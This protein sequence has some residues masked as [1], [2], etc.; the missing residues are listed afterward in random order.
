MGPQEQLSCILYEGLVCS[1]EEKCVIKN[2]TATLHKHLK[3][4]VLK[5]KGYR[6]VR[7]LHLVGMELIFT[8]DNVFLQCLGCLIN[9]NNNNKKDIDNLT[10]D[11]VHSH[12]EKPC[13]MQL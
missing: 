12:G 8:W 7:D 2:F 9:N 6:I 3:R 11:H 4:D 5:D 1:I 13:R 10:K